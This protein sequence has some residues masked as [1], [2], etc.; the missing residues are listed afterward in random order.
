MHICRGNFRSTFS[1]TGGYEDASEIIFSGLNVDGL[2][3]EFDDERSGGF[4][5]LRHVNRPD[6]SIVLGLITSKFAE[7]EDPEQIKAR[8]EEA[9]K[10][11]PLNQICLSPQ[12]GFAS[13]EE[14]NALTEEEQWAK[15]RHVVS[16]AKEVWK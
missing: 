6:L 3:L 13:T 1:S 8:I 15:I 9:T 12:C 16:I 5:P 11:I 4:E 7:L 2:F 10:Y 14:G